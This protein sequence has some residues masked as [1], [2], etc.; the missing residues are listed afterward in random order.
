MGGVGD[1][2]EDIT[3]VVEVMGDD[4]EKWVWLLKH[5]VEFT[6]SELH[7]HL[8]SHVLSHDIM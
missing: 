1:A 6:S 2:N 7:G 8:S 3:Q 5:L 4:K